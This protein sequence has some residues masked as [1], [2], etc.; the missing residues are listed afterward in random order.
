[1]DAAVSSVA[2]VGAVLSQAQFRVQYQAQIL[3][4]QQSVTDG[5]GAAALKLISTAMVATGA[6]G[7]DLDIMA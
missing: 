1:M 2:G 6:K 4:D 5:L 3:K 7:H